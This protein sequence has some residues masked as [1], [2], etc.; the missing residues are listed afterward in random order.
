M[1]LRRAAKQAVESIPAPIG[2]VL[3]HAPF[4]LRL[5]PQFARTRRRIEIL[6]EATPEFRR[7]YSLRRF[8]EITRYAYEHVPFYRHHYEA[9]GW[10]P[11]DLQ[12]F[13]DIKDV[14]LVHRSDLRSMPLDQRSVARRGDL[15]INTG[16]TSGTPLHFTVDKHAYA[17]EWAH[18]L[19]AWEGIGYR[20]VDARLT[21]RGKAGAR[22]ITYNAVHNEFLIDIFRDPAEIAEALDALL[23]TQSIRFIHG[24]PSAIASLIRHLESSSA[25][26]LEQLKQGVR[27][28]LLGSEYPA[29]HERASVE[30][31]LAAPS[32]SWY[33]HSEMAV[34]A[35]ERV[36]RYVYHPMLSYGFAEAV[37][38]ERG[39]VLVGTSFDNRAAPFI[40]YVTDDLVDITQA[41]ELVAS[42]RIAAG[43]AG[44][45]VV[46]SNGTPISVTALLFGRHHRAFEWS[47]SVQI[48]QDAPGH[49][50]IL[51]V[52][53]KPAGSR[54][55]DHFNFEGVP[56]AIAYAELPAPYRTPA[57]KRPLLIRAKQ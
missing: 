38:T 17:R 29:P 12:A 16:G 23:R 37:G 49:V 2:R 10:H 14:P 19:H 30:E 45:S 32:L 52:G 26:I 55:E 33:G 53:D 35:P 1:S 36:Q 27:G 7:N 44:D 3:A 39:E 43:R 51:V 40:R 31:Q 24:Y 18:M 5:G 21:L 50:T 46:R 4:G 48:R 47:E 20:R 57:G 8:R 54:L 25:P 9:V 28:V 6:E 11:D 22:A 15:P 42:F 56:L 41:D 34:F 13:S